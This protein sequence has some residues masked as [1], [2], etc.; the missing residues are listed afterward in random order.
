MSVAWIVKYTQGFDTRVDAEAGVE[1]GV[2]GGKDC[3]S[4]RLLLLMSLLQHWRRANQSTN[5]HDIKS[6]WVC[7]ANRT[8]DQRHS[9][10]NS[11]C[12][13]KFCEAMQSCHLRLKWHFLLLKHVWLAM[14]E[15]DGTS[16]S[17]VVRNI[18][19][20]LRLLGC[21]GK[22]ENSV[23][24]SGMHYMVMHLWRA[25]DHVAIL[26]SNEGCGLGKVKDF[27]FLSHIQT[28]RQKSQA[29]L[30]EDWRVSFRWFD[31]TQLH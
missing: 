11:I 12:F 27:R 26:G 21:R 31:S 15:G 20:L 8:F 3:D 2:V 17:S 14:N 24:N 7:T 1:A 5:W 16:K 25:W 10:N 9:Q 29:I 4:M 18:A 6:Q 22:L 23:R 30:F 19:N 13:I 28:Q